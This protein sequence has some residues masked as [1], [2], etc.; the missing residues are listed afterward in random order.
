MGDLGA[1]RGR[2]ID[3]RRA[4]VDV[5]ENLAFD[6]GHP[7]IGPVKTKASKRKVPLPRQTIEELDEHVETYGV[8]PTT[9]CSPLPRVT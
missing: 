5:V 9:S 4:T 2:R 1:L 3:S 7:V 6:N 8:A